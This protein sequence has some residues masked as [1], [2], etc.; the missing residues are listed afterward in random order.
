MKID[1]NSQFVSMSSQLK[2]DQEHRVIEISLHND[3]TQ[4]FTFCTDIQK[5]FKA[6]MINKDGSMKALKAISVSPLIKSI[7]S[8]AKTTEKFLSLK[9]LEDKETGNFSIGPFSLPS[10]DQEQPLRVSLEYHPP[11][12][13]PN[14]GFSGTDLNLNFSFYALSNQAIFELVAK[15]DDQV[16]LYIQPGAIDY[17]SHFEELLSSE[18]F[19]IRNAAIFA[20]AGIRRPQSTRALI[21]HLEKEEDLSL[22]SVCFRSIKNAPFDELRPDFEQLFFSKHVSEDEFPDMLQVEIIQAIS[23]MPDRKASLESLKKI[24]NKMGE[25]INKFFPG[26]YHHSTRFFMDMA[27]VKLGD[28]SKIQPILGKLLS[29]K[30]DI[31]LKDSLKALPFSESPKLAKALLPLLDRKDRG[32]RVQP[33]IEYRA[34]TKDEAE[35]VRRLLREEQAYVRIQDDAFFAISKILS[36]QS[37]SWNIANSRLRR[38][39]EDEFTRLKKIL[40]K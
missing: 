36:K 19:D 29:D 1:S 28:P 33:Y 40:I 17:V 39:S 6:S 18:D 27:L 9:H 3:S 22:F 4:D 11:E 8:Y 35:R 21:R 31:S 2:I 25:T 24:E 10:G 5:C 37:A 20:L 12:N 30:N 14:D 16:S 23:N 7:T 13:K 15:G 34:P 26:E 38:Y 32:S